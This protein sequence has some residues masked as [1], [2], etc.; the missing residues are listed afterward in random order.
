MAASIG[1]HMLYYYIGQVAW[2][3]PVFG[4]YHEAASNLFASKGREIWSPESTINYSLAR[5]QPMYT[6]FLAASYMIFDETWFG[7]AVSLSIVCGLAGFIAYLTGKKLFTSS[8]GIL[9]GFW[10]IFYPYYFFQGSP[11]N[12]YETML[13]TTL[14]LAT[15]F[16]LFW[17]Q[18]NTGIKYTFFTALFLALAALSRPKIV[19]VFPFLLI[20]YFLTSKHSM[21]NR[22]KQA[23][24]LPILFFTF[25]AP[26]TIRNQLT[27]GVSSPF[28]SYGG[29]NF[30]KAFHPMMLEY[31]QGT[32]PFS[33]P[34]YR[35]LSS[36]RVY[37]QGSLWDEQ[38]TLGMSTQ[39]VQAWETSMPWSYW[40]EHPAQ[41]FKLTTLKVIALWSWILEPVTLS[42]IK[43]FVYFAS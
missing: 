23:I 13:F 31:Y 35:S 24:V 12:I 6:F 37:E 5:R 39:Q 9:A 28:G 1:S 29:K 7:V 15:V 40:F 41:F 26:W 33:D 16:Y 3:V 25:L 42:G 10:V 43:Q 22:I 20:W 4:P 38:Q 18:E 36:D 34:R 11:P 14:L 8:I 19:F 30:Y 32:G 21:E 27:E 17:M 2:Q